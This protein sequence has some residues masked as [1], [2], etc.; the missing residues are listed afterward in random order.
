MRVIAISAFAISLLVA[1]LM[2]QS[3]P[4][5]TESAGA[6]IDL[7]AMHQTIDMKTLPEQHTSDPF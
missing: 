2:S 1:A 3:T 5:A 6:A 4:R 7:T